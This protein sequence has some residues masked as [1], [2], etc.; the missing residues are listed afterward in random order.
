MKRILGVVAGALSAVAVLGGA[1]AATINDGSFELPDAP[2]N[3]F[4]ANT[5]TLTGW[6]VSGGNIDIIDRG[7]WHAAHG[8]QSIDLNGDQAGAIQQTLTT[9]IGERYRVTF[10]L[11]G[12]PQ[13]GDAAKTVRVSATGG[14]PADYTF[15]RVNSSTDMKWEVKTYSFTATSVSSVLRFQSLESGA[16]GPALDHVTIAIE[17]GTMKDGCKKGTWRSLADRLGNDFR[18]QGDCVSYFATGGR[19]LA[20]R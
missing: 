4:I 17:T 8:R 9:V 3:S 2:D 5:T 11:S 12:N 6:T 14:I 18:N 13:G 10:R 16:H 15:S 1:V 19:N 20:A 7:F